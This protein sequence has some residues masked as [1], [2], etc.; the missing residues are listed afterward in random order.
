MI[1]RI[2]GQIEEFI[3]RGIL[4]RVGGLVYEVLLAAYQRQQL[5][6]YSLG[7]EIKLHTLEFLEGGMA[8][9][10]LRPVIIGFLSEQ[11]LEF[12]KLLTTV[13][14]MGPARALEALT[15]PVP[16]VARAIEDNDIKVLTSLRNV[17]EKGARQIVA[18]L[19]G[20]VAAFAAAASPN[21]DGVDVSKPESQTSTVSGE[22]VAEAQEILA[23]LG[24]SATE[25]KGMIQR[26]LASNIGF[27]SAEEIIEHIYR[28]PS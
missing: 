1:A 8:G 26:A 24:Y 23:R 3:P 18:E 6:Q 20:K 19:A 13:K 14:N 28:K 10:P 4:V 7:Q 2:Y 27:R 22:V 17:G 21:A 12:F 16:V 11:E 5:L 15:L 25:A 9:A